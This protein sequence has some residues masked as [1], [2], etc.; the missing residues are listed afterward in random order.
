MRY[1]SLP[2][3]SRRARELESS[4]CAEGSHW[5][6]SRQRGPA[7][8]LFERQG[9]QVRP[10]PVDFQ[11]RGRWAGPLWRDPSQWLPSAQALDSSSRALRELLGRLV[12][13][14]W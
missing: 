9:L 10:F 1:T 7:Q 13:R 2:S 3:S 11:T 12:Y 4:A 8:R 6:G 14:T 5:L